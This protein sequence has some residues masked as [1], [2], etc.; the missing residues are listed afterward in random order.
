M[1]VVFHF[2]LQNYFSRQTIKLQV[3]FKILKKIRGTRLGK[4]S[5]AS[6][7]RLS[8]LVTPGVLHVFSGTLR[9]QLRHNFEIGFYIDITFQFQII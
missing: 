2:C 1:Q 5:P 4:F 9:N 6:P 3:S 7:S 8:T